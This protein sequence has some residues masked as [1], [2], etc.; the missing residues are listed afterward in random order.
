MAK[1]R[2]CRENLYMCYYTCKMIPSIHSSFYHIHFLSSFISSRF[3]SCSSNIRIHLIF[4]AKSWNISF[5]D[6]LH[7]Q[8]LP[9]SPILTFSSISRRRAESIQS[10]WWFDL[11]TSLKW[12]DYHFKFRDL[13]MSWIFWFLILSKCN[14][15]NTWFKLNLINFFWAIS[16]K[17]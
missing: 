3:N 6:F 16:V 11:R 15:R 9:S 13:L 4:P 1:Q 5:V 7:F 10:L 14:F 12:D 2:Q 8:Q 17:L